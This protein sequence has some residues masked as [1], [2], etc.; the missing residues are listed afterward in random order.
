[1]KSRTPVL[2]NF[3]RILNQQ[4]ESM[5]YS[6]LHRNKE[7]DFVM[8]SFNNSAKRSVLLVGDDNIGKESILFGVLEH[9]SKELPSK[10]I[11]IC[12]LDIIQLVAGTKYR[13]QF[14]ERVKA[15]ENELTK[16]RNVVLYVEDFKMIFAKDFSVFLEEGE[17]GAESLNKSISI[18]DIYKTK[19]ENGEV[20]VV[21]MI[22]EKLYNEYSQEKIDFQN[23]FQ[24]LHVSELNEEET[25]DVLVSHKERLESYHSVEFSDEICAQCAEYA[26]LYFSDI[27]RPQNA[28]HVLDSL[29]AYVRT[30]KN[31]DKPKEL[32]E[33]QEKLRETI[34]LKSDYVK[35]QQY[36]AAADVRDEE[37]K[38]LRRIDQFEEEL[39][40]YKKE[41]PIDVSESYL[42][43]MLSSSLNH[44]IEDVKMKIPKEKKSYSSSDFFKEKFQDFDLNDKEGIIIENIPE[45]LKTCLQQY[46]VYFREFLFKV[47]GIKIFFN[48]SLIEEGLRLEI[49]PNEIGDGVKLQSWF[50][51]YMEYIYEKEEEF[52]VNF[53]TEVSDNEARIAMAE[54]KNQIRYLES[55]LE[56][57]AIAINALTSGNQSTMRRLQFPNKD[58]YFSNRNYSD[59]DDYLNAL[60]NLLE[61]VKVRAA[62]DLLKDYTS[63]SGDLSISGDEIIL[64]KSRLNSIEHEKLHEQISSDT[65]ITKKQNII[66]HILKIIKTLEEE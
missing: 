32:I 56:I 31:K 47:K 23:Y 38:I 55:Q 58:N 45:V 28:I 43:I 9:Q 51:E 19:I 12:K 27:N 25:L 64:L 22:S 46:I 42:Y 66:M 16:N 44:D 18:F 39:E 11:K 54:L 48:V 34:K 4:F 36:E 10:E 15:I 17:E 59:I 62:I 37:S 8:S 53:E 26:H 6:I 30:E 63:H 57:H 40:D 7:V 41:N 49:K 3:S 5:N 61:K 14:E 24:I 2:D 50:D 33:L 21:S 29:G 60:R 13:G 52:K 35:K 1:M 65:Y 20:T